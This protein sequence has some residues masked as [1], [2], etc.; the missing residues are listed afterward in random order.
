MREEE[1]AIRGRITTLI[2]R[3][4]KGKEKEVI[5]S[6]TVL[7]GED[8]GAEEVIVAEEEGAT[9]AMIPT[10][11]AKDKRNNLTILIVRFD[12]EQYRAQEDPSYFLLSPRYKS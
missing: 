9:E 2:T 11:P 8:T 4:R 5:P 12:T 6:P 1:E 10:T 7:V 3:A